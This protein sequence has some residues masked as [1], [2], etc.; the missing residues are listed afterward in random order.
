VLILIFG[1]NKMAYRGTN[2]HPYIVYKGYVVA[3]TFGTDNAP[4][5]GINIMIREVDSSSYIGKIFY[6]G[7]EIDCDNVDFNI[8]TDI[9]REIYRLLENKT[10]DIKELS[11]N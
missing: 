9:C 4:H 5:P 3:R 8:P 6:N 7:Y 2:I 11:V 10:I 1:E